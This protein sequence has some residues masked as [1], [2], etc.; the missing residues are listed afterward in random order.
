MRFS[1][2]G[3]RRQGFVELLAR[4]RRQRNRRGDR[5]GGR[6]GKC[7]A[8]AA[9]A[10][11]Q[12]AT[13]VSGFDYGDQQRQE[14]R[15]TMRPVREEDEDDRSVLKEGTNPKEV[16]EALA[17]A[18]RRSI[19]ERE[20]EVSVPRAG[21]RTRHELHRF[22]G[23]IERASEDMTSS[24]YKAA[25][26]ALAKHDV[27]IDD[28]VTALQAAA[29]AQ[30]VPPPHR[31]RNYSARVF[32]YRCRLIWL[33][34][35]AEPLPSSRRNLKKSRFYRFVRAAMPEEVRPPTE[36][37]GSKE[38]TGLVWALLRDARETEARGARFRTRVPPQ[39]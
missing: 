33:R 15:N 30:R 5:H 11:E 25:N 23:A 28:V 17:Y 29:G 9:R 18:A 4:R 8:P 1:V 3:A 6:R 14:I 38:I 32:I 36:A 7:R 22:A 20:R 13:V 10:A 26:E 35:A 27:S 24:I 12:A 21:K 2:F 37:K 34:Y 19:E 31:A 16:I 39:E